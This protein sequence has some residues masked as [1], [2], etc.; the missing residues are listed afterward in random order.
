MKVQS[1]LFSGPMINA[2]V[3]GSKTQTRRVLKP[4]PDFPPNPRGE[5]GFSAMTPDRHY[6]MRGWTKEDGPLTRHRPLPYWNGDLLYVRES[7]FQLGHWQ[8]VEGDWTRTGKQKWKFVA[9]STEIRFEKPPAFRKGRHSQDPWTSAWHK[10]LGRFM[11]RAASRLTLEVKSVRVERVA[12]I[13]QSDAIAEGVV[14]D[15]G[16]EPDIFYLPS[17]YLISGVNGPKGALPIDNHNDPRL[18][19]R[20]LINNLHGGD[21]WTENPYVVAVT[22]K[23][24][25]LNIDFLLS[26]RNAA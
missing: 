7:Y 24:H 13:S 15:N 17:S 11:P 10:R 9:D 2:L 22:F 14:N 21:L 25:H 26:E 16:S 23:V 5:I 6:E 12:S 1:I 8:A 3:A 18:V 4:Q 19:F 20:D